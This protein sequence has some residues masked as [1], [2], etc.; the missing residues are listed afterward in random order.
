MAT[1]RMPDEF[2]DLVSHHLPP[3]NP[4]GPR[5]GRPATPHRTVVKVLCYVLPTDCRRPDV[6]PGTGCST[7]ASSATTG[8]ISRDAS[9]AARTACSLP[10][11][12]AY[13]ASAADT[14][15]PAEPSS[16]GKR[17]LA[18]VRPATASP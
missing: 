1:S 16:P 17:G 3:E 5:G 10:E 7:A 12:A 2:F 4:V 18:R 13:A 15:R 14:S 11:P 6:P 9:S 8:T